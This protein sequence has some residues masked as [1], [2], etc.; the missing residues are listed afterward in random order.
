MPT[1]REQSGRIEHAHSVEC[2]NCGNIK[3]ETLR[4]HAR[5]DDV[6][7]QVPCSGSDHCTVMLC[8]ACRH[9]C[10]SCGLYTCAAHLAVVPAEGSSP[11]ELW[12]AICRADRPQIANN[13]DAVLVGALAA[14]A[15]EDAAI[16][17]ELLD[18]G[19]SFDE[20]RAAFSDGKMVN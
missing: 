1:Q 10:W 12:C 2:K 4:N 7:P 19:C 16:V 9:R 3:L 14:R 17:D 13:T 15:I 18:A 20:C 8:E 11:A 5:N 6:L